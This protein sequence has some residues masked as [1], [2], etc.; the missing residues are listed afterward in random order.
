MFYLFC[1]IAN[2]GICEHVPVLIVI[3]GVVSAVVS[4]VLWLDC[5]VDEGDPAVVRVHDEVRPVEE[6]PLVCA[7]RPATD[8]A[9][10]R[11]RGTVT[12]VGI[13]TGR[14]ANHVLVGI[15]LGKRMIWIE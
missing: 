2:A 5:A 15:L 13:A 1:H 4:D 8:G 7:V 6:L 14:L 11:L 3:A 9:L 12:R 10:G